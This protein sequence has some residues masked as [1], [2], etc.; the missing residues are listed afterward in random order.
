STLIGIIGVK[1]CAKIFDR[2]RK[3]RRAKTEENQPAS[4]PLSHAAPPAKRK[5]ER[6]RKRARK[7]GGAA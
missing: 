1:I 2:P 3:S 5:R 4:L 6:N 7:Q